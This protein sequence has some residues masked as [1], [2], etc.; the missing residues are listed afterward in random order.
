M[1]VAAA[2]VDAAVAT[3]SFRVVTPRTPVAGHH[4]QA[5]EGAFVITFGAEPKTQTR[6][7]PGLT[8]PMQFEM[9]FWEDKAAGHIFSAMATKMDTPKDMPFDAVAG[10]EGGV[11]NMMMAMGGQP[12]SRESLVWRGFLG[13]E[14]RFS[15]SSPE[16]KDVE[17]IVRMF[18]EPGQQRMFQFTVLAMGRDLDTSIANRFLDS[19]RSGLY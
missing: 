6:T 10:L 18:I 3:E 1:P 13:R 4:Y 9:A 2:G 15:G 19:A 7:V 12:L 5:P 11:T 17:G 8:E 14:V 16:G